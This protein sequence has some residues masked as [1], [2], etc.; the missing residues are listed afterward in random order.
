M[1]WSSVY[2]KIQ[3]ISCSSRCSLMEDADNFFPSVSLKEKLFL[4]QTRIISKM[5]LWFRVASCICCCYHACLVTNPICTQ[6]HPFY[7]GT[8][9]QVQV[10]WLPRNK[11]SVLS[12][13][14][15]WSYSLL[16]NCRIWGFG[17]LM[18]CWFSPTCWLRASMFDWWETASFS[19]LAS[20]LFPGKNHIPYFFNLPS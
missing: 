7:K 19:A 18:I 17:E 2:A 14:C 16:C 10:L 8:A 20:L 3:Q 5:F 4:P 6:S 12:R 15:A 9:V 13:L 1:I 11:P